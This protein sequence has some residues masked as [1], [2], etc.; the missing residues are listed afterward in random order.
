MKDHQPMPIQSIIRKAITDHLV[1]HQNNNH[2]KHFFYNNKNLRCRVKP[3]GYENQ[4]ELQIQKKF[5]F[6][7]FNVYKWKHIK[8]GFL[9]ENARFG[10]LRDSYRYGNVSE[11]YPSDKFDL[12][13]IV[14][15]FFLEYNASLLRK[16]EIKNQL[17]SYIKP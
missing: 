6:F 14:D 12:K 15:S 5:L 3:T 10:V 1:N 2:M 4:L 9:G 16:I 17:K 8:Q 11:L 13:G 7:W